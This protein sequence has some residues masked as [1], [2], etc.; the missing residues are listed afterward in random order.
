MKRYKL[1]SF[2]LAIAMIISVC[3]LNIFATGSSISGVEIKGIYETLETIAGTYT[4]NGD[5]KNL[6][7]EW[8]ASSEKNGEYA[9]IGGETTANLV[10][11]SSL[12]DKWVK[13]RVN[14]NTEKYDSEPVKIG[15]VWVGKPHILNDDSGRLLVV[16]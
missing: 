15:S 14:L 5:A 2:V 6:T 16:N 1:V 8:F 7:F 9:K 12:A 3:P 13:F 10:V 4:Y 11:N